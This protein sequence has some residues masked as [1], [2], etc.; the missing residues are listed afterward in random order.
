MGGHFHLS[1]YLK[2]I[3]TLILNRSYIIFQLKCSQNEAFQNSWDFQPTKSD[4][5]F[6]KNCLLVK[7]YQEIFFIASN[8]LRSSCTHFRRKILLKQL[9][10]ISQ[11]H[12]CLGDKSPV[13]SIPLWEADN[14]RAP[15]YPK[16][17]RSTSR[18]MLSGM[19]VRYRNVQCTSVG[20]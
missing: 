9:W 11:S 4:S 13:W 1:C 2:Y 15:T 8:K 19:E 18:G 20:T 16:L 3:I 14:T 7:S 12:K 6:Q 5:R 10:L 17:I